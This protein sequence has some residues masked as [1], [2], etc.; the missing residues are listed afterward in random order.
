MTESIFGTE[1]PVIL[2]GADGVDYSLGTRFVP[3][4]DG[5]ITHVKWRFPSVSQVGVTGGVFAVSGQTLLGSKLFSGV[6]LS[7]WNQVALDTPISVTSGVTYVAAVWIPSHYNATVSY[8]WPKT[9]TGGNLIAGAANGWFSAS[10]GSLAFPAGQSGGSASYFP[11]VVFE[12]AGGS[13]I[14]LSD[15]G[16]AVD[17][18]SIAV[19]ASLADAGD[20]YPSFDRRDVAVS[21]NTDGWWGY[22]AIL[23]YDEEELRREREARPSHCPVHFYPLDDARGTLHCGFGGEIFDYRGKYLYTQPQ[24]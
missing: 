5:T 23:K 8:P 16:A 21:A 14:S 11:D 3:Q 7:T 15:A 12:P 4:V 18:G 19:A 2:D 20:A 17:A 24:V 10:T 9:S 13:N 1:V 22:G 6:T